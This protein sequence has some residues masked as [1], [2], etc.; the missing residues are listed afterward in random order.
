MS[1]VAPLVGVA[2]GVEPNVKSTIEPAPASGTSAVT[3]SWSH[4]DRVALFTTFAATSFAY[5]FFGNPLF[6]AVAR[7]QCSTARLTVRRV[8]QE[9][10]T[11]HGYRGLFRGA[12]VAASGSVIS[13]LVYYLIVEYGKEHLPL[14]TKGQRSLIGG[15]AADLVSGP[16][17]NPFA[18]VSQVQMVADS[19]G[20][21]HRYRNGYHTTRVMLAEQGWRALFR[22]TLLTMV[23]SPLTGAWW[24]V[25]EL[26]KQ[27]A[28]SLAARAAPL[29]R[30]T[31]PIGVCQKLPVC[32]TSTRDN[33]LVNCV[34]GAL[35]SVVIGVLVNPLYVLRLRLQVT[36]KLQ[37]S[38]FPA[39]WILRSVLREEGVQAL[40]KGLR[41]NLFM[42]VLGGAAFG[43]TYEGAKQFS[44]I[45]EGGCV[46]LST[47][48]NGSR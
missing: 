27:R 14:P 12:G 30:A 15:F 37:H 24:L 17:F 46:A 29:L 28:Y 4:V 5:S 20:G 21:E 33:I 9:V 36:K 18:V 19:C 45:T 42:A 41:G 2:W 26:L 16:I 22:G 32:C 38:R 1:A 11:Q 6:L 48:G 39:F 25:Y 34:V 35:S 7:Q 13:E 23:V 8:L 47:Q 10:Y 3:R 31:T 43:M 40:F 44:D